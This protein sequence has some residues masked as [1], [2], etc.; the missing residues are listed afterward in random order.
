MICRKII[1]GKK[2]YFWFQKKIIFLLCVN[3]TQWKSNYTDEKKLIK[4]AKTKSRK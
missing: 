1:L 3:T 2:N 4:M